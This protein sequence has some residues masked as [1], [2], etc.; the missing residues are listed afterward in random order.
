MGGVSSKLSPEEYEWYEENTYFARVEITRL[1]K[2]FAKL[3]KAT[4]VMPREQFLSLPELK[5]NPFRFRIFEVFCASGEH[6]NFR[7][8]RLM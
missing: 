1:Y 7:F 4:M 6:V 2:I 8:Y 3:T 5:H